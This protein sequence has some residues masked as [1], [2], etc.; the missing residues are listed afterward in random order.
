MYLVME[1]DRVLAWHA[2]SPGFSPWWG[3][4]QAWWCTSVILMLERKRQGD[5]EYRVY[6]EFK[7][8]LD[9]MKLF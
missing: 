9:Y 6:C 3:M 8:S 2:G 7:I 4:H 5:P 1:L